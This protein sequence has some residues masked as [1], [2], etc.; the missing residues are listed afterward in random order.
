LYAAVDELTDKLDRQVARHKTKI[1]DHHHI[2][3]KRQPDLHA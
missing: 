2:S 1:K 3:A